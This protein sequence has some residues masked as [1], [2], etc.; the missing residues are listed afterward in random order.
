[1][2]TSAMKPLAMWFEKKE[3]ALVPI[4][5]ITLFYHGAEKNAFEQQALHLF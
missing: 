1:M 4:F 2:L 5:F 3:N